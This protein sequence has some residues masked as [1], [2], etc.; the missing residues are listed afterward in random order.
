[1]N[2]PETRIKIPIS[3]TTTC[4]LCEEEFKTV[5]ERNQHIKIRHGISLEEYHTQVYLGGKHPVCE[6][7]CGTPVSLIIFSTYFEYSQYTKNHFPRRGF[8]PEQKQKV[9]EGTKKAIQEKYGVDSI[10]LLPE[11]QKK[12]KEGFEKKYG[13]RNPMQVLEIKERNHHKQ[14]LETLERIRQ[15]N[16]LRYGS[17]HYIGSKQGREVIKNINLLRYGVEFAS[18]IP[19]GKEKRKQT[20]LER[21]GYVTSLLNP[22]Y[23]RKYRKKESRLEQK[24]REELGGDKF[25]IGSREFDIKVGNTL[26]EVD[27][28]YWHPEKLTYLSLSQL[29]NRVN[30]REKKLLAEQ[31]QL[32]LYHI[33]TSR[34]P[35]EITLENIIQNSYTPN[36]TLGY[37]DVVLSKEYL[38]KYKEEKGEEKLRKYIP[39]LYRF[40]QTFSPNLPSPDSRD[41]LQE[42]IQKLQDQ[43]YGYSIEKGFQNKNNIGVS[44]LKGMFKSYW[45]SSYKGNMSPEEVW[46]NPEKMMKIIEDRI[47]LNKRGEVFD[48]SLSNLIAGI[49]VHRYAV[50]FFRPYLAASIYRTYLGDVKSPVVF[51]PCMGFGGR[52]LGFKSL[53][54]DGTYIGVEPNLETFLELQQLVLEAGFTNVKL[55]NCKIEDFTEDIQYDFAFTS[56]PYFDL[57]TYS[58]GEG[59]YTCFMDWKERFIGKLLQYENMCI[60]V[61]KELAEKLQDVFQEHSRIYSNTS[62]FQTS[63]TVKYEPIL[64]KKPFLPSYLFKNQ[65]I[66]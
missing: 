62:P 66:L 12:M 33:H 58:N 40:L 27:G 35:E 19:E 30:D 11:H 23:R 56:I 8:T 57:E 63:R 10:A 44:Y 1:M 54:P 65:N 50:S 25:F 48:F 17:T 28:D 43:D 60:N 41:S 6:C 26:I 3:N 47:G 36:H 15:T 42:I 51:D 7:G 24:V 45:K 52:L 13:K 4:K 34:I 2:R 55:Y 18:Q 9:K 32:P 64:S 22:E 5:R 21:Y 46:K 38:R 16:L 29:Q 49:T 20:C 31:E 14:S 59:D 53:Y 39:L 37:R 61:N